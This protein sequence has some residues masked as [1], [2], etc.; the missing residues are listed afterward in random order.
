MT[1]IPHEA[2]RLFSVGEIAITYKA[3]HNAKKE[4]VTKSLDA[5]F[6]LRQYWS[7]RI[8]HVEEF[9][10]M[11]LNRANEVVGLYL[12]SIGGTSGTCVDPK[13]VFQVALGC[14]ASHII[15]AH[16]HPSGNMKASQADKDLTKKYQEIGLLLDCKI[17]D[18]FIIGPDPSVYFSFAD[19]GI[20]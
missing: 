2:T 14:H 7:E 4:R 6:I 8:N 5:F 15:L 18:H 3:D 12:V 13:I 16:N 9:Y 11:C 1:I 20:L 10:I 17:L 19:E